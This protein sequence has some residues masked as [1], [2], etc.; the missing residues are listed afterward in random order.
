MRVASPVEAEHLRS[1][2]LHPDSRK[3]C[4][5]D[6]GSLEHR[7]Q[8]HVDPVRR[9]VLGGGQISDLRCLEGLGTPRRGE[10]CPVLFT[11]IDRRQISGSP[12]MLELIAAKPPGS[13][14][15]VTLLRD[16][17]EITQVAI[18]GERPPI[19]GR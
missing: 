6:R 11:G 12:E 4:H 9:G 3:R 13:P 14:M 1:S 18:V 17:S 16:G 10:E 5:T 19:A 15:T 8:T 2:Q 7:H